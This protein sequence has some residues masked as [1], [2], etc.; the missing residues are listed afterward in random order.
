MGTLYKYTCR[1]CKYTANVSGGED[2]GFEIY[3]QTGFCTTCQK[4]IDYISALRPGSC[5]DHKTTEMGVCLACKS[6]ITQ[7]WNEGEPCPLCGGELGDRTFIM[8]WD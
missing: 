1:Q 2:F 3:T 8:D 7:N 5:L 6:A 4:L